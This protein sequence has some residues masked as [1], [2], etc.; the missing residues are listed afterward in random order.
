MLLRTRFL[1]YLK[2]IHCLLRHFEASS[3]FTNDARKGRHESPQMSSS[4]LKRTAGRRVFKPIEDTTDRKTAGRLRWN[5]AV[6]SDAFQKGIREVKLIQIMADCE[7]V[8]QIPT[9]QL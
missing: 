4:V 8:S 3:H 9:F 7:G 1:C 2:H 6:F 5:F